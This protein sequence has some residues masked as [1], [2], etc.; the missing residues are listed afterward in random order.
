M[1]NAD[2][3]LALN[4]MKKFIK[5]VEKAYDYISSRGKKKKASRRKGYI[6][7][8]PGPTFQPPHPGPTY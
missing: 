5:E 4:I 6:Q 8:C 3:H 1:K 7:L 2:L